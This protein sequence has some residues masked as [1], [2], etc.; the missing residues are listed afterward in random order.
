MPD[1][2]P[3]AEDA[4]DGAA[5]NAA[6]DAQASPR[7]PGRLSLPGGLSLPEVRIGHDI[8]I[9]IVAVLMFGVI[10]W[11]TPRFADPTNLLQIG[12]QIAL[13]AIVSVGLTYVVLVAEIDLSVGSMYGLLVGVMAILTINNGWNAWVAFGAIILIGMGLGFA[14]GAITTWFRVP[15]FIVT[16]G[17]L[18]LYLGTLELMS[19]GYPIFPFVNPPFSVI[20]G[21]FL[22]GT[23]PVQIFWLLGVAVIAELL[24][25]YTTFGYNV[26]A[27][28]G[29]DRAAAAVGIPVAWVK[30]RAFMLLGGLVGLAAGLNLGW[31]RTSTPQTGSTLLL[32]ALTAVIVGGT[33]LFGGVGNIYRT[34]VGS[35]IIAMVTNALILLRVSPYWDPVAKGAII[36]FAVLIGA[37]LRRRSE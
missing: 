35:V 7:R 16:L 28:G 30:I 37:I 5:T 22:F 20:T 31:L 1:P 19:G 13:T 36:V 24:L 26:Y 34:I 25:R 29:N 6:P 2:S 23:I 10:T 27:T 33:S 9:A 11:L 3:V 18:S 12:R 21:G 15:S 14:H 8:S 17:G 4:R 32:D